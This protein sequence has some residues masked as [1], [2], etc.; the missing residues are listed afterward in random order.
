[1]RKIAKWF[2]II[3]VLVGILGFIPGVT[4]NGHLLGIFEVNT[5]HNIIHLLSGII[6]FM[7]AGSVSGAKSFFKIFGVIYGI[8]TIV[9]FLQG[10]SVLGLFGVNAADNVLHLLISVIA[11]VLGFTRGS[12]APMAP[13]SSNMSQPSSG[14]QMM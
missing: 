11:L 6:A 9:G 5:L 7:C 4:S 14:G 3:F 2:G 1:M 10:N 8:V 13:M 12:K